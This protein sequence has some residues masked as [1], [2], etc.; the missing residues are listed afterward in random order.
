ME[1]IL[2]ILMIALGLTMLVCWIMVLIQMFKVQGALHGILGIICSLYAFIWGWMKATEL[3][4]KNVMLA[5]TGALVLYII[6]MVIYSVV[7][8]NR[9][10]SGY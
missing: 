9:I 5:W 10:A 1:I 7:V 4:L 6:L 3:K 2:T 8:G